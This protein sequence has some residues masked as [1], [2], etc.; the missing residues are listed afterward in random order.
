MTVYHYC[1]TETMFKVVD[2]KQLW[3]TD[4]DQMNDYMEGKWID[5]AVTHWLTDRNHTC[6]GSAHLNSIEN[7][8]ERS[9]VLMLCMSK[10][11][12]V[13]SQWRS[14]ANDG[15]GFSIGLSEDF[16]ER[17]REEIGKQV[18]LEEVIYNL[19]EQK[20]EISSFLGEAMD[21]FDAELK[22]NPPHM[23]ISLMP[24]TMQ[25]RHAREQDRG[26]VISE[27]LGQIMYKFK[28]PKFE[29]EQEIRIVVK[30][31]K[32]GIGV[33]AFEYHDG[34]GDVYQGKVKYYPTTDHLRPYIP[35]RLL[36]DDLEEIWIGPKNKTDE[37]ELDYFLTQQ[38]FG[39]VDIKRSDASYR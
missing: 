1:S 34:E 18:S 22:E 12:D 13:L 29:E 20:K 36:P 27:H 9:K 17:R 5:K 15:Q 24:P 14:Y 23:G 10:E 32:S 7:L 26:K 4:T 37:K 21:E 31:M 11:P 25:I 6:F 39:K 38:G 8:R 30:F 16:L 2:S 3:L 28:N 35:F 33:R 19:D